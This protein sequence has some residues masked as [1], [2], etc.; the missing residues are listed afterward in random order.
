MKYEMNR[1]VL[2]HLWCVWWL[3]RMWHGLRHHKG[4]CFFRK[5][6]RKSLSILHASIVFFH[7]QITSQDWLYS[8]CSLE[9]CIHIYTVFSPFKVSTFIDPT[10]TFFVHTRFTC[11]LISTFYTSTCVSWQYWCPQIASTTRFKSALLTRI[12]TIVCITILSI[13]QSCTWCYIDSWCHTPCMHVK[14][15]LLGSNWHLPAKP[16]NKTDVILQSWSGGLSV[17]FKSV[18]QVLSWL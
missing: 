12:N 13:R 15:V 14:Q 6:T 18:A 17:G 16:M 9:P 11:Q 3:P 5:H 4:R 2:I 10:K 8:Y 7:L 1:E